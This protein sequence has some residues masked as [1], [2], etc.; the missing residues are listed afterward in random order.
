MKRLELIK[1][2][3]GFTA[4]H[5]NGLYVD[6]LSANDFNWMI[7][8]IES[9]SEENEQLQRAHESLSNDHLVLKRSYAQTSLKLKRS[10]KDHVKKNNALDKIKRDFYKAKGGN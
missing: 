3:T 4:E 1:R 7:H 2:S 8:K 9:L 6:V 10:Q 5:G